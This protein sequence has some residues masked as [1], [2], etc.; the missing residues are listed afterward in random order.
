MRRFF[1]GTGLHEFTFG[2][3]EFPGRLVVAFALN[4]I[5]LA[6]MHLL[7]VD[8]RATQTRPKKQRLAGINASSMPIRA[9]VGSG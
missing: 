5:F 4:L 1:G 3:V 2:P 7:K 8:H 6:H 9:F